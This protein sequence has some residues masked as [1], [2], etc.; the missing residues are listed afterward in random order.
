MKA[1]GQAKRSTATPRVT[2][3]RADPGSTETRPV[4]RR[5]SAS[6][7]QATRRERAYLRAANAWLRW[8]DEEGESLDGENIF[9]I[10]EKE[11]GSRRRI[12]ENIFAIQENIFANPSQILDGENI[13]AIQDLHA[14]ASKWLADAEDEAYMAGACWEGGVGPDTPRARWVRALRRVAWRPRASRRLPYT[15]WRMPGVSGSSSGTSPPS[16]T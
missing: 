7:I 4:H 14:R 8:E 16:P 12:G 15:T 5:S 6:A 1:P 11:G 3:P 10:Q 9:A 2:R 13:F